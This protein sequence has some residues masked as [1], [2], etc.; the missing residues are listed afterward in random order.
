MLISH[1]VKSPNYDKRIGNNINYVI[2][3]YTQLPL[4]QAINAYKDPNIKLSAHYLICENGLIYNMVAEQQRAWHAGRSCWQGIDGINE[5]SI[6]IELDNLGTQPFTKPQ[7]ASLISL[8]LKLKEKYTIPTASFLGHSD[9]AA[10]RKV[11]PG[12]YFPWQELAQYNIG[13]WPASLNNLV[14][15]I[16][17]SYN[18]RGEGIYSLRSKL[19][20]LGYDITLNDIFDADL[21]H[22]IRAFKLKYLGK[23]LLKKYKI[24]AFHDQQ[25]QY[26]WL[27]SCQIILD[28]LLA[29]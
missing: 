9:I 19:A 18:D 14:D 6:G 10:A 26:N 12:V 8:C 16:V 11:D 24:T 29:Y 27:M 5:Y 3:H 21:N 4:V 20:K 15:D 23:F 2:F 28:Q 22:I 7:I 17:Y 1:A 25:T 13:L